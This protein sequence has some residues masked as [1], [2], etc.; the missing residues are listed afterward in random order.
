MIK[1]TLNFL[2]GFNV[3]KLNLNEN[4][5]SYPI[6]VAFYIKSKKLMG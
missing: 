3:V 5:F 2:L 1:H 6:G 4:F